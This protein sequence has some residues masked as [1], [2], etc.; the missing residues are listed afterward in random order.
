M[1]FDYLRLP[2][3][4]LIAYLAFGESADIWVWLGGALIATGA[5]YNARR[6]AAKAQQP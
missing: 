5:L 2:F 1:P 4:A 6:E 3:V